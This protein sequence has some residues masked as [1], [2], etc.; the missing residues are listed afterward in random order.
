MS[1]REQIPDTL[2]SLLEEPVAILG[3]GPGAKAVTQLLKKLGTESVIFDPYLMG[4]E[5]FSTSRAHSFSLVLH[6]QSLAPQ[7]PWISL[8]REA[9]CSVIFEL[10]FSQQLRRGPTLMVTGTNGKTTLQEFM[11]FALK[12]SGISAMAVGQHSYPLARLAMHEELDGVTAVCELDPQYAAALQAFRFDA[13][14]WTNCH[15]EHL[16]DLRSL[17]EFFTHVVRLA[18]LSP[19]APLYFGGSVFETAAELDLD[20]P[21]RVQRLTVEDEPEWELPSSSAFATNIHRSALALFLKYWRKQ[22]LPE[23]QLKSA[24]ENFEVRAHRL[25]LLSLIGKTAY[26]NDSKASNFAATRAA[27]SNFDGPVVWIGGGHY[28]GGDLERFAFEIRPKLHEAILIGDVADQLAKALEAEGASCLKVTS[29][30]EA[31]SAAHKAAAGRYPVVFS[32]G[33]IAGEHFGDFSQRGVCYENAVLGLK[34]Q[35][36]HH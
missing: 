33:F 11:T 21:E 24:A 23:S 1:L 26:W 18:D 19:E 32:P 22:K 15:E 14:F 20:L 25:H 27:L 34:H 10:D 36:G 13:L 31:V 16:S 28:R 3:S 7:H 35:M 17:R 5:A 29:L 8:A 9:G 4:I 12:R 6:T 30:N 2:A